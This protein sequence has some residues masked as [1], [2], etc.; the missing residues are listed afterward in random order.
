MD[1]T[2]RDAFGAALAGTVAAALGAP[3]S[4]APQRSGCAA[5]SRIEWRRGFDDRRIAD[6]GNGT[7]PLGALAGDVAHTLSK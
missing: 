2:R 3:A 1:I 4:A 6:L 7:F 5:A